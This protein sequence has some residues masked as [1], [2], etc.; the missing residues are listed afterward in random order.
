MPKD[1]GGDGRKSVRLDKWALADV[2]RRRHL[3]GTGGAVLL[4][5]T[6]LADER[7]A[8]YEGT[9]TE[10]HDYGRFARNTLSTAVEHLASAGALVI[11]RPFHSGRQGSARVVDY[12]E[13]VKLSPER[14]AAI[15]EAARRDIAPSD[16]N[17]QPDLRDPSASTSVGIREEIAKDDAKDLGKR[18]IPRSTALREVASPPPEPRDTDGSIAKHAVP[19]SDR[20]SVAPDGGVQFRAPAVARSDG[21]ARGG[22]ASAIP[23]RPALGAYLRARRDQERVSRAQPPADLLTNEFGPVEIEERQRPADETP[24]GRSFPLRQAPDDRTTP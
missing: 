19:L 3:T 8:T 24:T 17:A 1:S 23:N 5:M 2:G 13:L 14:T 9:L 12:A 16:A 7:S 21:E 15:A 4:Q 10:L 22:A 18:P 6:L 11:L 20:V